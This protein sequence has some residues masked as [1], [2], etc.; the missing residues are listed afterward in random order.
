[1]VIILMLI[2]NIININKPKDYWYDLDTEG[3][4]K[5]LYIFTMLESLI[6]YWVYIK[7]FSG[8]G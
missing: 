1:M 8:N 4:I 6:Y 3:G 2:Y 7:Y 5:V